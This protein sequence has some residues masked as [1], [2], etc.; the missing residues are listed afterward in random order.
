ERRAD[1]TVH[2]GTFRLALGGAPQR[3]QLHFGTVNLELGFVRQG[4]SAAL[5]WLLREGERLRGLGQQPSLP[6]ERHGRQITLYNAFAP[7]GGAI[8]IPLLI[9]SRGYGLFWRNPYPTVADLGHHR[10]D[11]GSLRPEQGAPEVVVLAG[12]TP[13]QLLEHYSEISG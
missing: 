5:R 12:A 10:P 4:Q 11:L 7:G 3:L 13:A 8:A 2:G 1:G 6:F 9:S